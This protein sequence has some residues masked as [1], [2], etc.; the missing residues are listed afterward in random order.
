V[1]QDQAH[2]PTDLQKEVGFWKDHRG[3]A[4]AGT[5][6]LLLD[7]ASKTWARHNLRAGESQPFLP[8][9]LNFSL[10]TNTG[11]AFSVGR[12]N[13]TIVLLTATLVF[14]LLLFWYHRQL[15]RGF[16]SRLEQYGLS[17][18][19]GAALGNLLDRYLYGR[20]TDFLEFAFVNF[21]VFN[22]A[23]VMIDIGIAL[24]ILSTFKHPKIAVDQS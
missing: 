14:A 5:F 20:V 15:K 1:S 10:V 12:D 4:M 19:I 16:Q 24:I 17:I 7:L 2:S 13:G 8:S 18:V 6:S 21:P 3:P 22:L 9:L 23:D 11:A